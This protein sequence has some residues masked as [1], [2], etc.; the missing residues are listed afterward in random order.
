MMSNNDKDDGDN[1]ND[2][3]MS[4]G[5]LW[6]S[7]REK[8]FPTVYLPLRMAKI[9]GL[10]NKCYVKFVSSEKGILIEKLR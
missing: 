2:N 4:A 6:L 10:D 1:D 9:H 7:G 8:K 3:D 5:R